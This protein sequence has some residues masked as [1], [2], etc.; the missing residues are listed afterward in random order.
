MS[1]T[2]NVNDQDEY[3][4]TVLHHAAAVAL[5]K[6]LNEVKSALALRAIVNARTTKKNH[7]FF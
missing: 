4:R 3:E 6:D 7:F 5:R 1:S 2:A